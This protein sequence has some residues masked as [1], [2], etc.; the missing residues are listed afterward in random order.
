MITRMWQNLFDLLLNIQKCLMLG[1]FQLCH[2]NVLLLLQHAR[3]YHLLMISCNN[4]DVTQSSWFLMDGIDFIL[5]ET[6]PDGKLQMGSLHPYRTCYINNQKSD[7]K[8]P[9][10]SNITSENCNI[11]PP[12]ATNR[13]GSLKEALMTHKW[14]QE[15]T[16]TSCRE[17]HRG[18]RVEGTLHFTSG[19]L[20]HNIVTKLA[21]ILF[22]G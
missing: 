12:M 17:V 18:Q 22:L 7:L 10:V 1:S 14:K 3:S 13:W 4:G 19:Y 20:N 8:H 9:Q 15:S 16:I 2:I 21:H 5:I 6:L 11:F